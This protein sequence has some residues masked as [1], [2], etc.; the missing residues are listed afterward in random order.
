MRHA[1]VVRHVVSVGDERD[2][3]RLAEGE[4]YL[5]VSKDRK[6]AK[7]LVLAGLYYWTEVPRVILFWA[8]FIVTRPFGAT[9]GDFLG[10]PHDHG[11]L[12]L[13][14]PIASGV[15]FILVCITFVP[16]RAG[17]HPNPRE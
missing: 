3:S 12:A 5:L 1:K 10:K 17:S 11:G 7:L 9:V 13:S 4:L 8:A 2:G 6:R 14:R 16:Q 15:L